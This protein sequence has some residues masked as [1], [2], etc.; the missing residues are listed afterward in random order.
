M[1][2]LIPIVNSFGLFLNVMKMFLQ[3]LPLFYNALQLWECPL[4]LKH[5]MDL[6]IQVI[7]LNNFVRNGTLFMSLASLLIHRGKLSLKGHIE[8]YKHNG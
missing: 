6:H 5:I 3:L 1:L 8:L 4:N 7:D 2:L